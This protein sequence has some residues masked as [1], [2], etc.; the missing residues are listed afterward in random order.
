MSLCPDDESS[1]GE[2]SAGDAS[3]GEGSAASGTEPTLRDITVKT[4]RNGP[5]CCRSHRACL[6][7]KTMKSRRDREG[8]ARPAATTLYCW[9]DEPS[10]GV[11]RGRR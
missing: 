5:N 3:E 6:R 11:D 7:K 1:E 8:R 10:V 2:G 9:S 4:A